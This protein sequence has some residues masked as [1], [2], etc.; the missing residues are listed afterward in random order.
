MI[1]VAKNNH[2]RQEQRTKLEN[3]RFNEVRQIA[4]V[5]EAEKEKDLINQITST[6]YKVGYIAREMS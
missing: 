1:R 3:T 6:G 2:N 5:L 4:Y